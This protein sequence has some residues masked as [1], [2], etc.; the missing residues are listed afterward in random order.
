MTTLTKAEEEIM[1]VIWRIGPCT[2]GQVREA[3]KKE[4]AEKPAHS[5]IS[6]VLRILVEKQFLTY[7]AYGR[8][9]E[10]HP[11]VSKEDYSRR[12]L[13]KLVRDY[14]E[15]STN[16]LVSFLVEKK[17][18]DVQG[19]NELLEKLEDRETE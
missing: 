4:S 14:F 8:T 2:V 19:L 1:Q 5:T 15:G 13:N 17:E 12:T 6:T 18:L 3:I 7:K 10:Y 9:F 16:R 11:A